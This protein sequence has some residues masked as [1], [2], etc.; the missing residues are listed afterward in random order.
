VRWPA[1]EPCV[2][3]RRKFRLEGGDNFSRQVSLDGEDIR[4]VAVVIFGPNVPVVLRVDQLYADSNAIASATDTAF[5]ECGYAQ[6]FAD[7]ACVACA[8]TAI[9]HDGHARDHLE[10][11]DLRKIRENVVLNAV[12]EVGVLFLVA[13]ILKW[14]HRN[15][16]V[17]LVRRDAW[18][19]KQSGGSGNEN[20]N[21]EKRDDVPAPGCAARSHGC[22]LDSLR[23][24]VEY[25]GEN[26]RHRKTDQQQYDDRAKNRVRNVKTRKDLSEPLR[27][28]PARHDVGDRNPVNF[29][30]LQFLQEAVHKTWLRWTAYRDHNSTIASSR[31][32]KAVAVSCLQRA[33]VG[34]SVAAH[35][36][37]VEVRMTDHT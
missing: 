7:F 6:C 11:A 15:R 31:V 35:D 17:D 36:L 13:Q 20:P 34:N 5:E 32:K 33:P 16:L 18:Q 2:F 10:I 28:R 9:R 30:P 23:R 19:N 8:I 24:H 14:H 37:V 26:K 27:E 25:P 3:I 21:S 22:G 12:G 29:S 1:I 4:Q